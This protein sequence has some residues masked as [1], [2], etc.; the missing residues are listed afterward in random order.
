MARPRPPGRLDALAR[1]ALELF[2]ERGY[3]R[4]QIAD[5]A[6]RVGVSPGSIYAYVSSKEALLE[7]ALLCAFGAEPR[8]GALPLRTPSRSTLVRQVRARLQRQLK[9]ARMG[10][11][12]R[13]TAPDDVGAE[14]RAVLGELYD[15][16]AENA[17]VIRLLERVAPDRPELGALYFGRLRVDVIER[18]RAYLARRIGEGRLRPVPDVPIAARLVIETTAWFAWHRLGDPF[19]QPMDAALARET[20]VEVLARGLL[21]GGNVP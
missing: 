16:L 21:P 3:R 9:R 6:K 7:L 15:G 2:S 10:A 4:T 18:V 14:L 1:A 17:A 19:P 12:A 11:L 20:V 8:A 13:R 5:V